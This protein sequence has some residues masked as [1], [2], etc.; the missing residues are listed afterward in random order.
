MN[1]LGGE[2]MQNIYEIPKEEFE[3]RIDKVKEQMSTRNLD[4]LFVFGTETE[5]QNVRYLSDYWT[6]FESS[7]VLISLNSDPLLLIGPESLSYA[8]S[9]SAIPDIRRLL[10]LRE[11]SEPDYPDAKL[12]CL[13]H[14]FEEV[15]GGAKIKRLGIVG[16]N[17]MPFPIYKEI[18]KSLSNTEIIDASDILSGMR[19]IKSQNEIEL[20]KKASKIAEIGLKAV[21]ENIRPGMTELQV[22]GIVL[23]AMYDA[24]MEHEAF[25][26]YVLGGTHSAHAVGR[27]S[28]K[29][30]KE[31]EIIQLG[32]PA[33]IG[34]YC[35]SIGR[36][37]VL[38]YI[39]NKTKE[40]LEVGL[41]RENLAISLIREGVELK[42]VAI[43]TSDFLRKKGYERY[44]LYGPA[45]AI[46]LVENEHPFVESN[47][48][49]I[50]KENMT[51]NIC[52]YLGNDQIGQRWE[53]AV[54][55]TRGGNPPE[56]F[57]SYKREI[58]VVK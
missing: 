6:S 43:K 42:E 10:L 53:D 19:M 40:F 8:K 33:K 23:K 2:E 39:P 1:H 55:V 27:A 18:K 46:G 26:V 41:E 56:E 32:I 17:F 24:G 48:I 3:K 36:P 21:L 11:S 54:R 14:I 25:Q 22:V 57:S 16:L 51:F 5:S 31:G 35:S 49:G 58:I 20:L 28:H 29:T 9:R 47:S 15:S 13:K 4:L 52:A 7:A 34:G 45:H 44:F 12:D 30:L 50:F 38:G 37:I